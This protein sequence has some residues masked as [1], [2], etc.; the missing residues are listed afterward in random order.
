M[1]VG[2]G[3]GEMAHSHLPHPISPCHLHPF[4]HYL[5]PAPISPPSSA[6]SHLGTP[7]SIQ[8]CKYI[9]ILL[10][11]SI[12]NYTYVHKYIYCIWV[13]LFFPLLF[14]THFL[15]A[16]TVLLCVVLDGFPVWGSNWGPLGGCR[17]FLI[18]IYM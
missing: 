3:S 2:K 18:F 17:V 5:L 10:I 1:G 7:I 11:Y 9:H 6:H 13:I 16:I 14:P 4:H 8:I 12:Y 15:H